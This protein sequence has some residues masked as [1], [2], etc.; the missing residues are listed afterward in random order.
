[1]REQAAFQG[2][3]SLCALESIT[4][5]KIA[6]HALASFIDKKSISR[7]SSALHRDISRQDSRIHV[8]QNHL[9]RLRIVPEQFPSPDSAFFF[10]HT[11][12]VH[13]RKMPEV[14]NLHRLVPVRFDGCAHT[15]ACSGCT[16]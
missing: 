10:E 3:I 7:Y 1:M 11:P 4:H 13:G 8:A 16:P 12:K 5:I 14:E 2:K 6:N 15:N 9:R